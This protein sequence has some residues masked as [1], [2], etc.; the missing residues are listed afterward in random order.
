MKKHHMGRIVIRLMALLILMSALI[1]L[2]CDDDDGNFTSISA[3]N[4]QANVA[5]RSFTIDGAAIDDEFAGLTGTLTIG[6]LNIDSDGDGNP[7]TA[8]FTLTVNGTTIGGTITVGNSCTIT[9]LFTDSEA[10]G[11]VAVDP[12]LSDLAETCEFNGDDGS[13]RLVFEDGEE[14]TSDPPTVIGDTPIFDLSVPLSPTYQVEPPTPLDNRPETGTA[15][16]LLLPGNVLVYT[17]TVNDLTPEDTLTNSHIHT[18]GVTENGGVLVTLVNAPVQLGRTADI[19]FPDPVNGTVTVTGS[20]PLTPDEADQLSDTAN[21]LYVNIHSDQVAPGLLRGQ[22]RQNIV[23]AFNPLL[24]P[25]NQVP[26][27]EGRSETGS[28]TIRLLDTNALA[29]NLKV[30]NLDAG[31]SLTNAHIHSGNSDETGGVFITL[32]GQQAGIEFVGSNVSLEASGVI[33]ATVAEVTELTDPNNPF[34]VNIHSVQEPSGLLRGQLREVGNQPPTADAG[35]DQTVTLGEGQ[36]STDV[37]LD[38]SGSSDAD[39]TIA[40]YTWTATTAG[41]PDPDDVMM[42]TVSLDEGIHTFSLVVTDDEGA[43]STADTVTIM[44]QAQAQL[45]GAQLYANNCTTCH[46]ADAQ[47]LPGGDV[48]GASAAEI[49]AAIDGNTGG[50]GSLSSLTT[51]EVVAIAEHLSTLTV[52]FSNDI[53]PIFTATDFGGGFTGG[54]AN[55]GCHS[56]GSPSQGLNLEAAQA[57]NNIVGVP[58]SVVTT[59][60][61]VE[62]NDPDNS[63]LYMKHTGATGISGSR[64]PIINMTFFDTTAGNKLL[65]V[66]RL[67]IEQGAPNN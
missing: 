45:D 7:D 30:S 3:A 10:E 34:Y 32:V 14:F 53:I 28:A 51:A 54:C 41:S 17:M 59:L 31:D 5:N 43:D 39:G 21:P 48:R 22:L 25:A 60:N 35:A 58:S 27:V 9:I 2:G 12:P 24:S 11:T 62:P 33:T 18:G 16:L 52:S 23:L 56:G 26:P 15:D 4:F 37:T 29:F 50:M 42:P 36:T 44:V 6:P 40:T 46:G 67:W 13:L 63:Y 8:A 47:G 38:G 66:E 55:S 19:V 64:M 65:R 1:I 61:L 57:Y 20:I 49:Q